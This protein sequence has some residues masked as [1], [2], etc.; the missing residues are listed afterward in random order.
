MR[1]HRKPRLRARL[2]DDLVCGD[3]G[4]GIWSERPAPTLSASST[5]LPHKDV[6]TDVSAYVMAPI[7]IDLWNEAKWI[8]TV[9]LL[10]KRQ[11]RYLV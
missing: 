6:K 8:G 11:P 10:S 5:L 3:D 2:V 4:E 9:F 7:D 1:G